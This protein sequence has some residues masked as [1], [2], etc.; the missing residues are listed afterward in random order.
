MYFRAIAM[1]KVH[2]PGERPRKTTAAEEAKAAPKKGLKEDKIEKIEIDEDD[3]LA[4]I[5]SLQKEEI[6]NRSNSCF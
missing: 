3:P 4:E 1:A 2:K 5:K 6:A